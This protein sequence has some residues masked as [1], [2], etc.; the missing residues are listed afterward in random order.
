VIGDNVLIAGHTMIIP[1]NHNS[2]DLQIPI[3]QQG[4]NSKGIIIEDDVWIGA[5]CKILDGVCIKSGAII[6]AGSVVT[7]D[8][9]PNAIIAGVPGKL[10]KY[11]I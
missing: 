7:K 10:I 6:G 5:G 3:N 1:S 9:P 4:E 11:R 2:Q 8:I